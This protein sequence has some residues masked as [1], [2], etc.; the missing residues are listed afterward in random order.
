MLPNKNNKK[1][2]HMNSKNFFHFQLLKFYT[3]LGNEKIVVYFKKKCFIWTLAEP[4]TL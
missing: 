4:S 3:I 2:F 1:S